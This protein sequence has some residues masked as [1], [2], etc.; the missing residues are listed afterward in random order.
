MSSENIGAVRGDE[1]RPLENT[2]RSDE[3]DEES[4]DVSIL[5]LGLLRFIVCSRRASTSLKLRL[6]WPC[7][8]L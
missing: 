1:A 5:E 6:S 8:A 2:G 4:E 3:L 7:W